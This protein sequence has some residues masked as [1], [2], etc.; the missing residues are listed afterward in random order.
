VEHACYQCGAPVEDGIPFCPKCTAPQIRVAIPE[1]P[2][3]TALEINAEPLPGFV[4]TLAN[5]IDWPQALPSVAWAVL[6][7]GVLTLFTFGSLGLGML[8]A[9]ALSVV[10]YRRNHRGF[11]LSAGAGARLGAMTGTLGFGVI[12]VGLAVAVFIFH[13]GAKIHGLLLT[14]M[15]DYMARHPNPDSQQVLE[16][17][18]TPT[19]IVFALILALFTCVAFSTAGGALGALF[20][21]RKHRL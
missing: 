2:A 20:F 21:R 9:G 14:A 18:K 7:A 6:L 15:Q 4:P 19:G 10:L 8:V 3:A 17:F 13:A 5:R 1:P 16:L 11:N 12:L